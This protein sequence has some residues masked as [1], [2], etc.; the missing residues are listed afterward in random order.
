MSINTDFLV[1]CIDKWEE[2]V[3][4]LQRRDPEETIHDMLRAASV[5][6][7]EVALEHSGSLLKKRLRPYFASSSMDGLGRVFDNIFIERLWRTVKYEDIYLNLY[8]TVPE[9]ISGLKRYFSFYNHE[10]QHQSLGYLAPA[11]VHFEQQLHS[12]DPP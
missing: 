2:T 8:D 3:E 12:E 9:L 6:E 5:R 4:Q 7:L 1:R 10:R 11:K